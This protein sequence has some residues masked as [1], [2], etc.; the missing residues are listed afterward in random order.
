MRI[1]TRFL[2]RRRLG[3]AFIVLI[4]L[5][6]GAWLAAKLL[7]VEAPLAHADAA[8]VLSGSRN[9]NERVSLA[10]EIFREGKIDRIVVTNDNQQGGWLSKEQ[11]NPYFYEVAVVELERQG[12]PR[13]SIVVLR[14][15]VLSTLDEAQLLKQY[16][17]DQELRSLLIVT[18]PYHTRR[19]LWL[20]RNVFSDTGKTVG[21]VSISPGSE[22]PTPQT[23]WLYRRG[24]V[25]V[26]GE[27]AKFAYS[28]VD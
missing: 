19:A 8:V 3:V 22:S 28:F 2:S 18:S 14:Q 12:V 13:E 26:A 4:V 27:Y 24:W 15:P 21:I 7:I 11:R 9:I 17:Q 16:S 23:W 25:M 1:R 20:F 5:W 10:A 6:L